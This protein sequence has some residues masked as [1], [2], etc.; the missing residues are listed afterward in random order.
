MITRAD[1][2]ADMAILIP[3]RS[4]PRIIDCINS[5][6]SDAPEVVIAL[7]D[8]TEEVESICEQLDGVTTVCVPRAGIGGALAVAA[9][10][11][12]RRYLVF[13]DSD[14][15]F[16]RGA[17][18]HLAEAL[19][20]GAAVARGE[21]L[22]ENGG[23]WSGRLIAEA[24]AANH[25][26]RANGYSPLLAVDRLITPDIGGY[27]F[28]VHLPFREDREFDFRLQLAG[29]AVVPTP[30]TVRHAPQRG[31]ADLRSAFRY[32]RGERLGRRM[33]LFA[34]PSRRW[35]ILD[36]GR[37]LLWYSRRCRPSVAGYLAV[38]TVVFWIGLTVPTHEEQGVP[39]T[40]F[41]VRAG[42]PMWTTELPR[43]YATALRRHHA[44]MGR[45]IKER[46]TRC[47]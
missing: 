19:Q 42:V 5:I 41:R 26:G 7:N 21:V 3:V 29:Y 34:T 39:G 15:R 2:L 17:L 47:P 10:A 11:T 16:D 45:I 25:D 33:G 40:A 27:L 46:T 43:P 13:T 38:W 12:D 32:G 6:D 31:A 18:D 4:D 9:D 14:C 22:Y 28:S 8:P 30:A 36:L 23:T 20:A 37:S 24:R 44:E 1:V 35:T